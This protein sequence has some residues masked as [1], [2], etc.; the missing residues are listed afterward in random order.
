MCL[1]AAAILSAASMVTQVTLS[2]LAQPNSGQALVG[3]VS[4]AGQGFP[5]GTI[6]PANV[7]VTLSP[8]VAGGGPG[9][10]AQATSI[11]PASGTN[12][13]IVF[14]IP[15]SIAVSTPTAYQVTIAGSTSAGAQFISRN[16]AAL[17][18][19]PPA[20]ISSVSPN[21]ANAALTLPV[22][23]AAQY[24]DFIQGATVA[25]FGPYV[26]V[27]GAPEGQA[28]PIT[29]TSPTAATAQITI[30][31]AAAAGPVTVTVVTGNRSVVL[32]GAFM[33]D[34]A[35]AVVKVTTTA[36]TPL[37]PRFSGFND[38]SLVTG[39]EYTDP[40]YIAMIRPMKP[41]FIR[42]PG[43]T[44]SMAF[45]WQA[46]HQNQAWISELAPVVSAFDLG[47]LQ[48]AQKM[49]QAKGGACFTSTTAGGCYANYADLVNSL[50]AATL[51][52]FNGWTDNNPGSAANMVAAAQAAGLNVIEWEFSNEP[53]LFPD[54]FPTASSYAASQAPYAQSIFSANPSAPVGV[55][56]QGEFM[57]FYGSNYK[58]W[59][60]GMA[61]YPQPYWNAVSMH[62]YP[63]N[64]TAWTVTQEE[65]ILNGVLAH[66]TNEYIN[67]YVLPSIGADTPLFITEMNSGELGSPG[68]PA[69]IYNG[70]FLAEYIARMSTASNVKGIAV[71][72]LFL[73]NS[74]SQGVIR[75]VNDFQTYLLTQLALNPDYST[76]TATDPNTQFVFYPSANALALQVVN[77]AV[78]SSTFTW[79]TTVSG[80]PTVPIMGYDGKPVPA[81][82]AQGY[83]GA[84]G[85]HFV[86]ITNKSGVPVPLGVEVNGAL[87]PASVTATYISSPSD[88]AQNTATAQDTVQLV[89]TGWSNPMI[90][91]PYSVTTLQW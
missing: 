20:S 66:G 70:I 36:A 76:N 80:G 57:N 86:V 63:M 21:S 10:T 26:S 18:V 77:Q 61:A 1:L 89:S 24:T 64:N 81:I 30:N 82:F 35:V 29:V 46:G 53:Y 51:V 75:A 13:R 43:G 65:Q 88:T 55:F 48:L 16:S 54:I 9:G 34:A 37:A 4:V 84:D 17:T 12:L 50:G 73:G 72:P 27:G 67:S 38:P 32:A 7:T 23:I 44:Q 83:Q 56:Y 11:T 22:V 74:Y 90:V 2:N 3:F 87:G 8:A 40:K 69:Y 41:G 45:D 71:H 47:E 49:T 28:G 42:F 68:F 25:S 31:P 15:A 14:Q 33:I 79:A 62:V 91:G 59:D 6:P 60:T 19:D 5:S 39:V 52:D 85:T 78:N 58:A